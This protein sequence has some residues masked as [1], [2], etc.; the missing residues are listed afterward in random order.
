ML[1]DKKNQITTEAAEAFDAFIKSFKEFETTKIERIKCWEFMNCNQAQ[2]RICPAYTKSA[3]RRCWLVAGTLSG[4]KPECTHC[5]M[6]A[7]CKECEFYQ[8][9]KK[10]EI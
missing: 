2:C 4:T 10:G 5:K 6:I 3:G 8:K 9:I 7:S 1:K